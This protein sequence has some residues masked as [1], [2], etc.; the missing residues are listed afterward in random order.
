MC[1][2]ACDKCILN[3][4]VSSLSISFCISIWSDDQLKNDPRTSVASKQSIQGKTFWNSKII[5]TIVIGI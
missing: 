5:P 4:F 2:Q 1:V 3:T